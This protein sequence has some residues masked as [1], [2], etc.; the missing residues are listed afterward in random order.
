MWKESQMPIYFIRHGQSEFNARFPDVYEDHMPDPLVFDARLSA[1]GREQ[2]IAARTRISELRIDRVITSPL[3]RA[4]ETALHIFEGSVPISVSDLHREIQ[5][6]S[7]DIGRPP[8]DLARDFPALAFDHLA[9]CWWHDGPGNA[10]GVPIEPEAVYQGRI[11]RFREDM[12]TAKDQHL[13]VIGHGAFFEE[14]IGRMLDNC[15]IHQYQP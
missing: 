9:D 15:E 10:H 6:H 4:I 13:A 2:S 7:C 5:V 3:T 11:T 14:L 8:A 1:L 12:D